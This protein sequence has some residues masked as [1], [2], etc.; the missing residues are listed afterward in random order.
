MASS[1]NS[2]V[3]RTREIG[4]RAALGASPNAIIRLVMRDGTSVM[5]CGLITGLCGA[6]LLSTALR[7]VF[8]GVSSL[9]A[10]SYGATALLLGIVG[11]IA[12]YVPA[13]R[14]TRVPAASA[15]RQL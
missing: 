3:R 9:D 10:I 6:V 15:L 11:L 5:V 4:I 12:C 2:V 14:A 1:P 8:W 13:R 7:R